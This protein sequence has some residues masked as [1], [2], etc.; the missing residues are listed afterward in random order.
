MRATAAVL[1]GL[2]CTLPSFAW[3]APEAEACVAEVGRLTERFPVDAEGEQARPIAGA[4]GARK[5]AG[6]SEEQRRAI[7]DEID[8]A[9]AAGERGD[10]A[11][12]I[13]HLTAARTALRQGGVGGV[14]PGMAGSSGA[15]GSPGGGGTSSGAPGA[16]P[17]VLGGPNRPGSARGTGSITGGGRTGGS[18]GGSLGGGASTGGSSGGGGL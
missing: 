8:A 15:M 4:A 13:E 16:S 6:L 7:G 10:G 2:W 11:G 12:C 9:R 18:T 17:D 14:Q 1:V 5:G 3:A